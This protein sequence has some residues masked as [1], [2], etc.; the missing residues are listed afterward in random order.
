MEGEFGMGLLLDRSYWV[1]VANRLWDLRTARF[2]VLPAENVQAMMQL[3]CK[4]FGD[5]ATDRGFE[6][7]LN[8]VADPAAAT[9][10]GIAIAQFFEEF[11]RAE[12]AILLQAGVDDR[13]A[14]E[15][16]ALARRM[17]ELIPDEADHPFDADRFRDLILHARR[18]ACDA[19]KTRLSAQQEIQNRPLWNRC[20]RTANGAATVALNVTAPV[21]I[22]LVEPFSGAAAAYALAKSIKAGEQMVKEGWSGAY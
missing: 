9:A 5:L 10:E 14:K 17:L 1:H 7:D 20:F 21:G 2:E 4:A 12:R 6:Q 8:L 3:C 18:M 19:A 22:T 15:L 11:E 16:G 13:A